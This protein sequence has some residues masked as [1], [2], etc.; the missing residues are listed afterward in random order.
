MKK[1]DRCGP[2]GSHSPRQPQIMQ[3]SYKSEVIIHGQ[4]RRQQTVSLR[5]RTSII[6]E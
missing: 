6:P 1:E 3:F 2:T 4:G 5:E